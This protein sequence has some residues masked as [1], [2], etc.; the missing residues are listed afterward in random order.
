MKKL[1]ISGGKGRFAKEIIKQNTEYEILALS[2]EDMDITNSQS[3]ENAVCNFNPDIFLHPAALTRPMIKHVQHPDIS[4]KTNIIGTSNVCLACMKHNVKLV[5]ISTDFVY[6]GTKGDYTE[7]DALYPV[8][9]YAW[10]KLGGECA[11]HIYPNSLIVRACMTE[12]PFVHPKALVDSKKSMLYIDEAA[13]LC[14]RI[15]DQYGIINLGGRPTTPYEFAKTENNNVDKI[16]RK[17]IAEPMAE[18]TTMNIEKL[19]RAL[20]C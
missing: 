11:V 20:L 9:N 17:D 13:G 14:L 4:I 12:R 10:T 7:E 19:K 3:I 6:P 8:N 16:F 2:K 5:Y 1:L 18:D 15:L